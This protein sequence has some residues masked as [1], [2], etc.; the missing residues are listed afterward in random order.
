M[1][2]TAES[3]EQLRQTM[4]K[5]WEQSEKDWENQGK[6]RLTMPR[7]PRQIAPTNARRIAFSPATTQPAQAKRTIAP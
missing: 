2:E 1:A 7:S 3:F 5:T 6:S 4:Q